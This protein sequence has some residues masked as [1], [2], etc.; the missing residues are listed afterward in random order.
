MSNNKRE[1]YEAILPE[2]TMNA[3][4]LERRAEEAER[5]TIKLKKAQY[6]QRFIGEEFE[7]VVSGITKWGIYVELPNTVEGLV[8]VVNMKDDHYDYDEVTYQMIGEHTRKTFSLGQKVCVRVIGC[9]IIAHTIDFE[10]VKE[11]KSRNGK[12]TGKVDCE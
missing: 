1:H 12:E 10:L 7:G 2:V 4:T 3:S 9:D 6:M 8:H 11:R 5:E